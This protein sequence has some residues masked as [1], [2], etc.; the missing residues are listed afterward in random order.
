[1]R[2][3]RMSPERAPGRN[4]PCPCGS[5]KKFK[6][7][8]MDATRNAGRGRSGRANARGA[9]LTL[10]VETP[11]GVMER[12][13]PSA[14]PL[15]VE[16]RQGYAAEAAVHDAASVWGLPDF[17]YRGHTRELGSGT[18]ELGDGIVIVRDLGVVVQVKSREHASPSPEKERSWLEKQTAQALRQGAGTVRQLQRGEVELTNLR[19]ASVAVDAA[20]HRWVIVVVLDHPDPPV[21]VAPPL[22]GVR[23]PAVVLLRRDWEFLFDQLKSTHAV[24]AYLD[25]VADE[26]LPLGQEPVRYYELAQADAAAPP[27][28]FPAERVAAPRVVVSGPLLPMEPAAS[29]DRSAHQVFRAIL[30]DIATTRL[31]TAAE[32]DRQRVLGELDSLPVLQRAAVG[33]FVLEALEK[34]AAHGDDGVLWQLRTVAG[35]GGRTHLGFGAC[36]RQATEE[37]RTAFS[38]W[39]QLRHHDI[40]SA[41]GSPD[42]VTTVAVLITPRTDGRRAWDT[43]MTAVAGDLQFTPEE[44]ATL[45]SVWP[46]PTGENGGTS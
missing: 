36:S 31:T 15:S 26:S 5:G 29:S 28:E 43:T 41:T 38:W 22:D 35:E 13:I 14:S 27:A 11:R 21:E 7:C 6:R 34:V 18:R 12:V 44:L 33:R 32:T 10:L 23:Q 45:R 16:V 39:V 40:V 19:G 37:I 4:E 46:T 25:R 3:E 2:R 8:C 9:E 1:M 30:E 17:V 20:A 42:A 24:A